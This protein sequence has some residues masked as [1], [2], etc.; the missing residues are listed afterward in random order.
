LENKSGAAEKGGGGEELRSGKPT[1]RVRN[2]DRPALQIYRPGM[3]KRSTS[4]SKGD[5]APASD[6]SKAKADE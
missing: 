2:K 5:D 4:D 6:D 1:Q 3:L